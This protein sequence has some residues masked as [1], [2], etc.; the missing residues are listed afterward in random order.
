MRQFATALRGQPFVRKV[1]GNHSKRVSCLLLLAV[2]GLGACGTGAPPASEKAPEP[3]SQL[4][5]ELQAVY[6]RSCAVCH[7]VPGTG[8]PAAGDVEAWAERGNQGIDALLDHVISGYRGMP[9]MGM[10][11]DC[12]QDDL[13]AFVEYMSGLECE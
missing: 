4:S 10:C 12:S 5:D 1:R 6:D 2:L 9:P 13:L 8:A 7:G 11:M 3:F